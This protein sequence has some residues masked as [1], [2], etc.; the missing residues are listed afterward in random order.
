MPLSVRAAI[1][2][3]VLA[4]LPGACAAD[5][6][7]DAISLAYQ[8]NPDLRAQQEQLRSVDESYVQARAGYGPQV[9][10]TSQVAY[11]DARVQEPPSFFTPKTTTTY[12]AGTASADLS[13][14]Q[15]LYTNGAVSAQ[16]RS[17]A[18]NV[19]A[20]RQSLRQAEGQL[21]L[22]V[23]TAYV[24]VRRDRQTIDVLKDEIVVLDGEL[25][26]TRAKGKLGVV[27][28]TDVAQAEARLLST[29]AQLDQAQGRLAVS[30]AEYLNVVGE[31]PGD[32]APEPELPGL[33][34]TVDEAF[35]A[36]DSNN[37]QLQA[38]V[39]S[40]RAARSQ[41]DQAKAAYGPTISL[42]V[43]AAIAPTEPFIPKQYDQSVTAA[44]VLNQPIF[45]SGLNA[46]KIRQASDEDARAALTIEVTR[47]GVVQ[48]VA[49]AW[50]QLTS[51]E[52]AGQR[53]ERQV[54]VEEVAAAGNRIEERAGLRTTIDLLNA[55]SELVESRLSL[56]GSR[57][58][59][60]VA[61]A[62]LLASMG[63]L[64]ARY[65]LPGAQAYDPVRS[66]DRVKGVNAP[67][68]EGAV[69]VVDGL[70]P[71]RTAPPAVSAPDAGAE[72]PI[73]LDPSLDPNHETMS[74]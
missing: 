6:L 21:L 55:E 43:D 63:M 32:L 67:P 35:V 24:D 39:D 20:G 72:R 71:V 17:A 45:T 29:E 57:H 16:V 38:A 41:V 62:A 59:D 25:A 73:G 66:L 12:Y 2:G 9:G 68:W 37:P 10:V 53:E 3:G 48:L 47:R 34:A 52:S 40:E 44:V 7:F 1:C 30:D 11:Q 64:E 4:C 56:I 65:L 22:N 15:P 74:H 54:S 50:S 8:T 26:E 61:K 60:Y 42:K 46:S 13:F 5:T 33:P 51:A 28:K 18:A 23:I 31:N 14:S 27:S 69:G 36:A 49:Q 19:L 58:D 70:A